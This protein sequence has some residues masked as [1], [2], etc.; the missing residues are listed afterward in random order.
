MPRL[1]KHGKQIDRSLSAA[2][3]PGRRCEVEEVHQ[4][5][6]RQTRRDGHGAGHRLPKQHA[7]FG[8]AGRGKQRIHKIMGDKLART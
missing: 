8:K 7:R 1:A 2:N 5:A 4:A 6:L 3:G